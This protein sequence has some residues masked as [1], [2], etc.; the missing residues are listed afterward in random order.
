MLVGPSSF[1]MAEYAFNQTNWRGQEL[2]TEN[3]GTST[4]TFWP[5]VRQRMAFPDRVS[6]DPNRH[7]EQGT[8]GALGHRSLFCLQDSEKPL[9]KVKH[10]KER[11]RKHSPLLH[12]L[13][14]LSREPPDSPTWDFSN[15]FHVS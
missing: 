14:A 3:T 15:R 6:M 12:K 5:K 8:V 13:P 4:S 10:V 9:A 7:K 11:E 1:L 2:G